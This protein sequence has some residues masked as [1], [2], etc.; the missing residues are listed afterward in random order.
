MKYRFFSVRAQAADADQEALNAFCAQCRVIAVEKHLVADGGASFWAVC[1]SYLDGAE[2]QRN[3]GKRDRIDYKEVLN[4]TDF[5]VFA[6]LRVLRKTLAEQE[7]IPPYALFTNEQLAEMVR[8]RTLAVSA[9][10]AIEGVGKAR[11]EKYGEAFVALLR[12]ASSQVA[13]ERNE[14]HG[15]QAG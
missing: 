13:Q 4:E 3:A 2:A 8:Q 10:A 9:L 14:T 15:T 11:V 12:H 1:V 7:G 5:A 6:E